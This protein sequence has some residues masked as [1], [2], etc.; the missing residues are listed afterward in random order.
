MSNGREL[1]AA[2]AIPGYAAGTWSI[3]AV[4][5][6]LRFTVKHLGVQTV[7]GTLRIEGQI[8]VADDPSGSAVVATVDLGSVDTKSKGRDKAI[9]SASLLDIA[10]HPTAE[11][12]STGVNPD[13][14]GGNPQGFVL[15]GELTF[16]GVT[17][18]VPLRIQVERF[19][20]DEGRTRPIL[21]GQGQ[22]ARRDFGLVYRARP[23]FL[24]RG[25][26]QTVH[27]EIRLEGSP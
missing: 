12:R 7:R 5:S 1:S 22:F 18:P 4:R 3:D 24:D 17:R 13:V 10:S 8:V 25:I 11:Y 23:R 9:R 6:T 26:G 20:Q 2:A 21:I 19:I 14:A 27:M 15:D 16:M